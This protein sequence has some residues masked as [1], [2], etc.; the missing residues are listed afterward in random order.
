MTG[1]KFIGDLIMFW[2]LVHYLACS[3]N[4]LQARFPILALNVFSRQTNSGRRGV[5]VYE[6]GTFPHFTDIAPGEVPD[7]PLDSHTTTHNHQH[8]VYP[9]PRHE[10]LDGVYHRPEHPPPL[11]VHTVQ[12]TP[13]D[14][15]VVEIENDDNIEVD[16]QHE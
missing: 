12:F 11:Q 16:G 13:Q 7:L 10:N 9:D 1:F 2:W 14:P 4:V 8:Q 3:A 5:W 15:E 6:I